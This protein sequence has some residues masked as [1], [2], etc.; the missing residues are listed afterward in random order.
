MKKE[1]KTRA[2]GKFVQV[3]T[4]KSQN[5]YY[6]A[7]VSKAPTADMRDFEDRVVKYAMETRIFADRFMARAQ[8]ETAKEFHARLIA[9]LKAPDA[10]NYSAGLDEKERAQFDASDHGQ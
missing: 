2:E 4:N 6:V 8:E 7:V 10:L 9:E 3:L 5:V 1:N